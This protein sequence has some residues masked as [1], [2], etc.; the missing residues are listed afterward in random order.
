MISEHQRRGEGG[1]G[2]IEGVILNLLQRSD[3][4]LLSKKLKKKLKINNNT[5][6]FFGGSYHVKKENATVH[7]LKSFLLHGST[8]IHMK[9]LFLH[10]CTLMWPFYGKASSFFMDVD[11]LMNW[12][13]IKISNQS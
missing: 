5:D 7:S 11:Y 10:E 3:D 9:K 6:N 4:F 13:C 2:K 8:L 1:G 12:G